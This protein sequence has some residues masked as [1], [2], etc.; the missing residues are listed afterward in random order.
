MA[1]GLLFLVIPG[2]YLGVRWIFSPLATLDP[3]LREGESQSSTASLSISTDL[4][5]G[6]MLD[7]FVI[8]VLLSVINGAVTAVSAGFG[9]VITVPFTFCVLAV[10]Y[11]Q[12]L[13]ATRPALSLSKG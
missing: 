1:V 3:R 6:R 2:I 10:C 12:S 4:T 11:E 7:L 13:K 8:G 9:G 5:R